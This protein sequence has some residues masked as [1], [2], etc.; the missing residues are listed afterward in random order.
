[1]HEFSHCVIH[2]IE[3]GIIYLKGKTV[4]T[5][6]ENRQDKI[7]DNSQNAIC[8]RN[9]SNKRIDSLSNDNVLHKEISIELPAKVDGS[10]VEVTCQQR[11]KMCS[12]SF[13]ED[14][15]IVSIEAP[16]KNVSKHQVQKYK[17]KQKLQRINEKDPL[18]D[19]QKP[20][21]T[22]L[23]SIKTNHKPL[24]ENNKQRKNTAQ[25][26]NQNAKQKEHGPFQVTFYPPTSTN[27]PNIIHKDPSFK[28]TYEKT[29]GFKT[30]NTVQDLVD[31][32]P[33]STNTQK[34]HLNSSNGMQNCITN[35]KLDGID[36]N[37]KI[38]NQN[39]NSNPNKE[40]TPNKSDFDKLKRLF[41]YHEE[42]NNVEG[43]KKFKEKYQKSGE[44]V[45]NEIDLSKKKNVIVERR[46]ED[47][48]SNE[49][50]V[51]KAIDSNN[52]YYRISSKN[53][54][55]ITKDQF[56]VKLTPSKTYQNPL[57]N[58]LKNSEHL[59]DNDINIICERYNNNDDYADF[60]EIMIKNIKINKNANTFS[61]VCKRIDQK[62]ESNSVKRCKTTTKSPPSPRSKSL[63]HKYNDSQKEDNVSNYFVQD[64][65]TCNE[66]NIKQL[67]SN[68]LLSNQHAVKVIPS[69]IDEISVNE[70]KNFESGSIFLRPERNS[71][72][73][74]ELEDLLESL[75]ET[76]L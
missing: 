51:Y 74:E 75:E 28:V 5:K 33:G 25:L 36:N 12:C 29:S 44:C 10:E 8:I 27:K 42:K 35:N 1:M 47:L 14:C 60:N 57:H 45:K 55:I 65:R 9:Q 4:D 59:I 34:M 22:I 15:V 7:E 6:N 2:H 20:N 40:I 52:N 11:N 17:E 13:A 73:V 43:V 32:T 19:G 70:K 67:D 21:S 37:T 3:K 53:E 61:A 26:H 72:V 24:I 50:A 58:G 39:N 18:F 71:V 16:F 31:V 63:P 62:G 41:E 64:F 69:F 66:N 46:N 76:C 23:E 68:I 56:N 54:E 48:S 30:N 38:T 49:E